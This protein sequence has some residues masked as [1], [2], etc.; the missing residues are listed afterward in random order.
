[1][2][3]VLE[4]VERVFW[5]APAD[6]LATPLLNF[7]HG[8]TL[9]VRDAFENVLF[10]GSPG[11]GK[12]TAAGTYY[13]ALL[14]E[15]FGGLVLCVKDKQA[16]SFIKL[17]RECGRENDLIVLGINGEHR[18]NP[19]EGASLTAATSLLVE[20]A[21]VLSGRGPAANEEAAFWRQQCEIMI[22]QLLTLCR[23]NY[24]RLDIG[25]VA[26][27]FKGRATDLNKLADPGWH[28]NSVMAGA[29]EKARSSSDEDL[30]RAVEYFEQDYPTHGDRLQGSLAATVN[31]VLENLASRRM[32]NIFGGES[33]F[34]MR[35]LFLGGKICVVA[36][37]TQGCEASDI[38]PVEGKI[39]NGLLQFCFC[40]AAA[41]SKHETNVFLVSDECQ[42]T[43]SHE[44]RRQLSVLR[45]YRVATV[46]LTQ[47]LPSL[48]AKLGEVERKAI[49]AKCKTKIFLRQDDGDTRQWAAGEIGKA[50]KEQEVHSKTHHKGTS[51]R[52]VTMQTVEEWRVRPETF[53]TLETGGPG[54]GWVV[55]SK[56]LQSGKCWH[57]RWHQLK[58]GTDGTVAI[59]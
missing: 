35:D 19:L 18:F 40:R 15:Q 54:N 28:Q 55:Q 44:L 41:Q 39:A 42:E 37:P 30:Q 32:R 46:L 43:I 38:A 8:H 7:S 36:I 53:A 12:T 58:P 59:A 16:D 27:M 23:S 11:S 29:L 2:N 17:C 51:S 49:L 25:D 10:I 14:Q 34:T 33:T 6:A 4:A 21:D 20:L 5:G 45:E 26:R 1:M 48:D 56:V 24:G 47:D 52:T 22:R 57:E 3:R 13:R 50:K 31:G 9:T